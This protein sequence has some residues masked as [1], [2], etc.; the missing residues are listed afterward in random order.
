MGRRLTK[1]ILIPLPGRQQRE[2]LLNLALRKVAMAPDVDVARLAARLEGNR[3][4]RQ[5]RLGG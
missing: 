5:R 1:R 4:G 3:C 2:A